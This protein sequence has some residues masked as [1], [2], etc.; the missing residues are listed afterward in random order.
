MK[1]G[2]ITKEQI[3]PHQPCQLG[4]GLN[5]VK[6][7]YYVKIF[8]SI[9]LCSK[10]VRGQL[11]LKF[12]D[13]ERIVELSN[14]GEVYAFLRQNYDE[15]SFSGKINSFDLDSNLT[16][17]FIYKIDSN[18]NKVDFSFFSSDSILIFKGERQFNIYG[19]LVSE[20]FYAKS[21]IERFA[22]WP[23]NIYYKLNLE[24]SD[25]VKL[26]YINKY[27][28]NKFLVK[29]T[30]KRDDE[31]ILKSKRVKN[32]KGFTEKVKFK[33]LFHSSHKV[34]YVNHLIDEDET[35]IKSFFKGK[36]I[37]NEKKINYNS[38]GEITNIKEVIAGGLIFEQKVLSYR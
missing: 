4:N 5:L 22:I 15:T 26:E 8:F 6:M 37:L 13:K 32:G 10:G 24:G 18:N 9:F 1:L 2:I 34:M 11:D 3:L 28:K 35:R 16:S 17:F 25:F 19:D 38:S 36:E 30:I 31:L 29:Q 20:S 7:N 14:N 23:V 33:K 21:K 12:D 27:D